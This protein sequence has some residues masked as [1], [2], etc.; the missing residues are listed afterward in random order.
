MDYHA[1][2]FLQRLEAVPLGRLRFLVGDPKGKAKSERDERSL[3]D[4]YAE[5]GIFFEPGINKIEDGILKVQTFFKLGKIKIFSNLRNTI[6][7]LTELY[8]YPDITEG[9]N[10]KQNL[11]DKPQDKDNHAADCLR[12]FINE[13]P[14]NP[15]ELINHSVSSRDVYVVSSKNEHLPHELQDNDSSY[16]EEDWLSYY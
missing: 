11:G 12:Y 14:D 8:K 5:Y 6:K 15:S 2:Q 7:E 13:L 1:E 10:D 3:F 16:G 4:H 9:K